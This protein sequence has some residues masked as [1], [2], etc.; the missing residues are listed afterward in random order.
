[1]ATPRVLT[2]NLHEPYLCM[3]AETGLPLD[4]GLYES[5]FMA[6]TWHEPFRSVPANLT[7]VAEST[8]RAR[9]D[10]G[11]YDVVIAHNES[12]ALDV[13]T[14]KASRIL[15]CHNRLSFLRTT[16]PVDNPEG[17]TAF[18]LLVDQL[19]HFFEFVFIS[20]TKQRDYGIPGRVILPGFDVEAWGGY[21]GEIP[22]IIRVGNTMRQRDRMFDVD[23]QEACCAGLDSRVVGVNPLIP[24][25]EPSRSFADLKEIYRSH[26]C[27]LHVSRE[28][29][30]DGYNLA[31]LEAMACGMPVAALANATSP[32]TNE[33]DGFVSAD[34]A[35]L[36]GYLARLLEDPAY[37]R[38][39]GAQGRETVARKF[40]LSAFVAKWRETIFA[41][42]DRKH[43]TPSPGTAAKKTIGVPTL[44]TFINAPHTTGRYIRDAMRQSH[45]TV[46]TG[47]HIPDEMLL[48][49]GFPAP[50]PPYPAHDIETSPEP[51]LH[52][53]TARLP[54]GFTPR[55]LLWVDSGQNEL[56][57][58]LKEIPATKVAWFIDT[59]VSIDHRIVI[60]RHFDYVFLA[61]KAQIPQFQA[62]GIKRVAWL[63]LACAAE[64][65]RIPPCPRD[66]DIAFVGSL[67]SA[68][69]KKRAEF[70]DAMRSTFPNHF[71]GHAW[72][73]EMA[74]HYGRAKI[75]VNMCV[76]EDVNM[77]V[78]EAMGSGAM[79]VT[80]PAIG[81]ED[82]FEDG[83]E[84][85]IYRDLDDALAKVRRYLD[86]DEG[87][88]RI[89][90]AGQAKVMDAHTYAHRTATMI[91]EVQKVCGPLAKPMLH[92]DPKSAEEYYEHP[93]RELLPAIPQRARR[94]L[95][96]GC[97]AGAL[98]KVLKEERNVEVVCGVEYI[99]EAYERARKVLDHVLLGNIE[100]ME[101]PWD[102]GYFN[103]IVCADVL[104]HLVDPS[105]VLAK[106]NRVLSPQGLIIISVP[107][108]RFF[109]VVQML[110]YGSWTYHEQ[111]IMDATHLR[112]FTRIDLRTMIE[113]GGM[114]AADILP[115]NQ[116][117][118]SHLSKNDD[119]SLSLGLFT[120]ENVDDAT[121]DELLT[122]QWLA[123]VCKPGFD[124]LALA[125][126]AMD[127]GEYGVALGLT[128]D[129]IGVDE[130][131]QY[132][133]AARALARLGQLEKADETYRTLLEKT[134]SPEIIGE[135][136]ILLVALNEPTKARA[137]LEE[138]LAAL[139][140]FDRADGALGLLKY[141]AGD[142]DGAYPHLERALAASFSNRGLLESF[143]DVA[144]RLGR[145]E[146]ALPTMQ[147]YL[148]FFPGNLDLKITYARVLCDLGDPAGAREQVALVLMF[149][150]THEGALALQ[151]ALDESGDGS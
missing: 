111:G 120:Y 4:V 55:L 49:W 109:D 129:A 46:S 15:V 9:L 103:C 71:I 141:Q 118:P 31:M 147:S 32:I 78:F 29:Y 79:L 104:E 61:Q 135:Y 52:E 105:A 95:D 99:E 73:H 12:N 83:R 108:A 53:I 41:A 22:R 20:E 94:I 125:R 149:E 16:I 92:H 18:Q 112:F 150:A 2:F 57:P 14:A 102:D 91:E 121:Y 27:L 134:D 89:A 48:T 101:L 86:D 106:L 37:A 122:Y 8:W 84:L 110:S 70:I 93:R 47:A 17:V 54:P 124:P 3:M 132:S 50:V 13:A 140:G 87:R 19:P 58:G 117:P 137:F 131:E 90:A 6:R 5:G 138:A 21:R 1:M 7:F 25:S 56:A 88:T 24:G 60:A 76:N 130:I 34:S 126:Q 68:S 40:P 80:D 143:V 30:E 97:G 100:E 148:E 42:A 144:A 43:A 66:L 139:P 136:G 44:I 69:G 146:A 133:I 115:L 11:Y 26:R 72:P 65:H 67:V 107:N 59:H 127:A 38:A 39:I 128:A 113:N 35:V 63:P 116:Y 45:P 96:V 75:V 28:E 151:K 123:V 23:F 85:V 98:G 114:E 142:L 77:R 145:L 81:L 74:A 119:G 51:A 36:R 33:Q 82:L 64:L 62:A 10:S